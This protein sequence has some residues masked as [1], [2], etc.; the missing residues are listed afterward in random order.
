[1]LR[2][3]FH[4]EKSAETAIHAARIKVWIGAFVVKIDV[5][6][7]IRLKAVPT[8]NLSDCVIL[9]LDDLLLNFCNLVPLFGYHVGTELASTFDFFVEACYL[10][11]QILQFGF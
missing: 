7:D 9:A 5:V 3:V 1:M 6:A 8:A 10:G 4:F 11:L 2:D